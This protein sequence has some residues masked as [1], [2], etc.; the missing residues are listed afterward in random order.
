[1]NKPQRAL[2]PSS[3]QSFP[4]HLSHSS[5]RTYIKRFL[6]NGDKMKSKISETREVC[7]RY[8]K[9]TAFEG[10][11]KEIRRNSKDLEFIS[12]VLEDNP[13]STGRAGPSESPGNKEVPLALFSISCFE[14]CKSFFTS[15]LFLG[16]CFSKWSPDCLHQN[17]LGDSLKCSFCVPSDP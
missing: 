17:H 4:N 10:I 11:R 13:S 16:G 14:V 6:L 15:Y 3:L 9:T 12:G 5:S 1:M 2:A 7:H 8:E